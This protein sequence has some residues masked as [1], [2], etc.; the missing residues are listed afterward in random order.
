MRLMACCAMCGAKMKRYEKYAATN[1]VE[2]FLEPAL[3]IAAA[4]LRR[5]ADTTHKL[6]PLAPLARELEGHPSA[7]VAEA[8]AAFA[9]CLQDAAGTGTEQ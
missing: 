6:A 7:H 9:A 5:G 1:T 2:P 4:L 8:A 3:A